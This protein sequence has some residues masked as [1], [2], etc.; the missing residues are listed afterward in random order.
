MAMIA[1]DHVHQFRH[2]S[3]AIADPSIIFQVSTFAL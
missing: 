3:A 2:D 1:T